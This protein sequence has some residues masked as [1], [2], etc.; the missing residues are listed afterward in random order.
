MYFDG[1]YLKIGSGAGVVLMSPQGHKLCYTICLYFDATN[2]VTNHVALINGHQIVAKV[3]AR[4][5][6][7]SGGFKLVVNQVMKAMEPH[8]PWMCV[9]YSEV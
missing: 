7:V 3:R 6:L 4:R 9:Y 1:S 2:N 8:D 5:L